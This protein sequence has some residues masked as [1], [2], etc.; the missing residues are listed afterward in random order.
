[1]GIEPIPK[2]WQGFMHPLTPYTHNIWWRGRELN[3]DLRI[4]SPPSY[5]W[6]TARCVVSEKGFEPLTYW[7]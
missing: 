2:P 6:T 3:P 7:V 4:M 1:M 5:H